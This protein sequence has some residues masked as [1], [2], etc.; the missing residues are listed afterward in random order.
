ME[1]SSYTYT[2][3]KL[4]DTSE[5]RCHLLACSVISTSISLNINE[6]QCKLKNILR[7]FFILTPDFNLL[8]PNNP[9]AVII[10]PG[11]SQWCTQICDT[12]IFQ[13]S[14]AHVE[15]VWRAQNK[16]SKHKCV[17]KKNQGC[18]NYGRKKVCL[19]RIPSLIVRRWLRKQVCWVFKMDQNHKCCMCSDSSPVLSWFFRAERVA[20]ESSF[21][22]LC[23]SPTC[24]PGNHR[25]VSHFHLTLL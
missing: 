15:A 9:P 18:S 16:N 24:Q 23:I 14:H 6:Q 7:Y 11:Q 13:I 2:W 21:H 4:A 22:P 5:R 20:S 1:L 25:N 8:W 17:V 19:C 10:C 3:P 12:P